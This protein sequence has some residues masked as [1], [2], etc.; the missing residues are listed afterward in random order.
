MPCQT[1]PIRLKASATARA[2]DNV[3]G[4]VRL[5][6]FSGMTAGSS[7]SDGTGSGEAGVACPENASEFGVTSG[8]SGVSNARRKQKTTLSEINQAEI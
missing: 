5:F 8:S 6:F 1:F 2:I 4:E 3:R 7:G